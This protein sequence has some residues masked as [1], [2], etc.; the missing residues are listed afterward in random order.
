MNR[1]R[2]QIQDR[3]RRRTT[4]ARFFM[5]VVILLL[6]ASFFRLQVLRASRYELRSEKNRLRAISVPAPRGTVYDRDGRV[7]AENVP[8]YSISLLPGRPDTVRA[9]LDR[10]A[11][12]LGIGP[13]EREALMEDYR[14][15]PTRPLVVEE[16][17][18]FAE[19][20][21]VEERRPQFRRAVVE[22]RPRRR[23]PAGR[24]TGHLTGYVGEVSQAELADSLFLG[25]E[26]GR[27]VGKTGLE[28]EYESRLGGE[29]GV[30]YVEVNALGSIVREFGTGSGVRPTPGEDL[31]LGLD[32]GLQAFTDSVF[33][34][35]RRGGVVALDPDTGE[36][37]LLYSHPGFDPN[38][39]V[40]G[41]EP[42]HWQS[43]RDDPAKPLLNR[44]TGA[45]YSPGST[46]KLAMATE[47]MRRD[48]V[49]IDDRME[50]P[51]RGAFRYGRRLFR[52]WKPEGHGALD[53]SQAVKRSCN[54]YFYQLGLRLGLDA[55]M[56]GAD[57][58]GFDERTGIDLP[59]E[60]R[61]HFPTS[62]DWFDRRYGPR[63]WTE[64]VA[65]NLAIG[66]GEN[67]QT[68]L[69]L[70]LFYSALAT[71]ERPVVPH[72]A[73]G[74][75]LEE[76]RVDWRLGIPE[77]HRRELVEAMRRVVN[78]EGGTAYAYRLR[79][80]EMAGKTGTAQNPQ[81]EPHSWFVGFA[82]VEDP[83]IVV[84]S[85]VEFGHPDNQTSLAVPLASR[86][87][88]RFLEERHPDQV[89][90]LTPARRVRNL[91]RPR[92]GAE[93][94][95]T[96]AAPDAAEVPAD[97]APAAG[98]VGGAPTDTAGSAPDTAGTEPG[99]TGGGGA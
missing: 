29:P 6:L 80:W 77:E 45:A 46:W 23:Y 54:V 87:V 17:A 15:A 35:G 39:F 72:L 32:L 11:P 98:D 48:L 40:G 66:Q 38:A 42:S 63:G 90:R 96:G 83:E 73:R 93:V 81:G 9:A 99:A 56:E 30:R 47:A 36:V 59:H 26:P 8:G 41:V 71:G 51:C 37:L 50:I 88:R 27:V 97:S 24:I 2:D 61:G 49:G 43:L 60:T 65:L 84:A 55:I 53:L 91:Y 94:D 89:E 16:D 12:Y 68:L 22:M 21:A 19:V 67:S 74:E 28:R 25:Y 58:L 14:E 44:V 33:P 1:G 31:R 69:R 62:R 57:R 70:A 75:D 79:R 52:C 95:T 85:L 76:R 10:L 18:T 78:E 5:G 64:S 82:P 92:R 86:V 13:E 3:R 34:A 7:V 20:S 4:G